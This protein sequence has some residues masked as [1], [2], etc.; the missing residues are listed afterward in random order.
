MEKELLEKEKKSQPP[1]LSHKLTRPRWKQQKAAQAQ[2][3]DRIELQCRDKKR[4]GLDCS[5]EWPGHE[6]EP[7]EDVPGLGESLKF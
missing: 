6:Y 5:E 2:R 3:A 7:S 1:G 4:V